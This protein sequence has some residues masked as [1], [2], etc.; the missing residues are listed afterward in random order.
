MKRNKML[1]AGLLGA[2]LLLV[3]TGLWAQSEGNHCSRDERKNCL[4][5]SWS[6]IVQTASGQNLRALATFSPG[7]GVVET[8]TAQGAP[9]TVH[10]SWA[11]SKDHR[12]QFDLT[13]ITFPLVPG[14]GT[15]AMAKTKETVTL[16]DSGDSFTFVFVL[17]AMDANG[18][19][20]ATLPGTGTGKRLAVEP[21][22]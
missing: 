11:A 8:N 2:T 12:D 14:P 7:G 19:V 1:V 10:A 16:S 5:G 21:L 22:N 6:E 9:V 20:I 3:P 17:E 13:F 15:F 4:L 18:N